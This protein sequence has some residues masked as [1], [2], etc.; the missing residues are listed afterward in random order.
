MGFSHV[1]SLSDAAGHVA[2]RESFSTTDGGTAQS[3]QRERPVSQSVNR[4]R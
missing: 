2:S 4:L 3:E 1:L